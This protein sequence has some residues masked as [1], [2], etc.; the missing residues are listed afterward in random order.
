MNAVQTLR[1]GDRGLIVA[2]SHN[3]SSAVLVAGLLVGFASAAWQGEGEPSG[4]RPSGQDQRSPYRASEILK[5]VTFDFSSHDRRA[6]G[7][8]NWPITWAKDDH[9]YTTWGDGGGFG[10][11]G[12]LHGLT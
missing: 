5:E 3:L 10:G 6:P 12:V 11:T 2:T 8:D 7:S 1:R 9:Q 4:V